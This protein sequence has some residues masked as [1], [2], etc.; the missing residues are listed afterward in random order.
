MDLNELLVFAGVVRAGSFTRAGKALGLPT[1]TIS[2]KVAALERRLGAMLIQRT[3]R[4]MSLTESG[5]VYL[6][7][8]LRALDEAE[9]AEHAVVQLNQA[10]R[11]LLRVVAPMNLG[12]LLGPVIAD[13]LISYPEVELDIVCTD[14]TVNLVEERF[15]LAIRLGTME[16]SSLVARSLFGVPSFLVASPYYLARYG[17][18]RKPE[19]LSEHRCMAFGSGPYFKAIELTK[20]RKLVRVPVKSPLKANDFDALRAAVLGGVGIGLLPSWRCLEDLAAKRLERVLPDWT[21][22]IVA[23]HIVS[24]GGRVTA[25]AARAFVDH[26]IEKLP[27]DEAMFPLDPSGRIGSGAV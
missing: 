22:P 18:P 26:L 6:N 8:C 23:M 9:A 10:P 3:T 11:G 21:P 7:H 25:P 20:I 1:S 17:R 14:R 27:R 24:A 15:A 19:E 12:R 5:K 2:R 4:K 13:Y 16:D